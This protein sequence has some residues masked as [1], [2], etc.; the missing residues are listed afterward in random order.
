MFPENAIIL[1]YAKMVVGQS[2]VD[3]E[4]LVTT[5]KT[6]LMPVNLLNST[7]PPTVFSDIKDNCWGSGLRCILDVTNVTEK[8][9][10]NEVLDVRLLFEESTAVYHEHGMTLLQI[11]NQTENQQCTYLIKDY[12]SQKYF[13]IPWSLSTS[14]YDGWAA[15]YKPVARIPA[16]RTMT[17]KFKERRNKLK[18]PQF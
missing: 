13:Y 4:L 10:E 1:P 3:L 8:P 11:C 6:Q 9:A 2:F 14:N 17:K 12:I 5:N 18:P 15:G 16:L 7:L